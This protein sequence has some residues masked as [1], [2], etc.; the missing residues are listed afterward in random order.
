MKIGT[1]VLFL[2]V[3][4]ISY[5]FCHTESFVRYSAWF[6]EKGRSRVGIFT[7]DCLSTFIVTKRGNVLSG[8]WANGFVSQHSKQG[9][10]TARNFMVKGFKARQC[11][12]LRV[13]NL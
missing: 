12:Q 5:C 11:K 8:R 9:N 13:N 1:V 2:I 7:L 10:M 3:I 6:S 4:S